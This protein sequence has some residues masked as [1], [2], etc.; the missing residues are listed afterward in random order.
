MYK[1][2]NGEKNKYNQIQNYT[3]ISH[4]HPTFNQK[5]KLSNLSCEF[6]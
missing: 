5:Q 2:M 6:Q 4:I 3:A 1:A